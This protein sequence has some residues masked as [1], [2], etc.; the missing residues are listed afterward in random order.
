MQ[1]SGHDHDVRSTFQAGTASS[2]LLDR[3]GRVL[4]V[5]ARG[6][7]AVEEDGEEQA[8]GDRCGS[9]QDHRAISVPLTL[10]KTGLSRSLTDSPLCSSDRIEARTAQLPKLIV[11]VQLLKLDV[12][13]QWKPA[14]QV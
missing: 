7:A 8:T 5:K 6:M 13:V 3:L 2:S 11:Q 1:L 9:G 14:T 4:R 10:V 12:A